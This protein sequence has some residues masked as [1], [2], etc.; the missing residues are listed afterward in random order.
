MEG[1]NLANVLNVYFNKRSSLL[2]ENNNQVKPCSLGL[3]PMVIVSP[4]RLIRKEKKCFCFHD[5]SVNCSAGAITFNLMTFII[6]PLSL[7]MPSILTLGIITLSIRLVS[8]VI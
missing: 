2:L 4:G 3:K 1:L 6:M 7:T 5:Y 8:I